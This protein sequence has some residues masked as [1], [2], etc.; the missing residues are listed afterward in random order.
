MLLS[1][2]R[3]VVPAPKSSG[4]GEMGSV[5]GKARFGGVTGTVCSC[6]F[7]GKVTCS[8]Y[9]ITAKLGAVYSSP[10]SEFTVQTGRLAWL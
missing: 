2:K 7:P 1:E 5:Q 3:V 10:D 8:A 6:P 9:Q 4:P